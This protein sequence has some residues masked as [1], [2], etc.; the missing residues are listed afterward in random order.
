MSEHVWVIKIRDSLMLSMYSQNSMLCGGL[1]YVCYNAYSYCHTLVST[2]IILTAVIYIRQSCINETDVTLLAWLPQT[3]ISILLYLLPRDLNILTSL[4][5]LILITFGVLFCKPSV[6]AGKG[7]LFGEA[8]G[9][10]GVS[11]VGGLSTLA[12]GMACEAC[13]LAA[14]SLMHTTLKLGHLYFLAVL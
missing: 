13:L 6:I 4:K 7:S 1:I 14:S 11:V 9:A 8:V 3:S 10:E 2:H 5:G 12:A